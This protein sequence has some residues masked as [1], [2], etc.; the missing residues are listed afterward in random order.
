MFFLIFYTEK[1]SIKFTFPLPLRLECVVYYKE[2][3]RTE[4]GS[5]MKKYLLALDEGTTSARAI[6]FDRAGHIAAMA[7]QP[8][9]QIYPHPGWVEQDPMDIYAA[10][11]AALT[12][13]VAKS[14]IDPCEIAAAGITNQRE[15]ALLWDRTTGSPVAPAIVWQCRRTAD[16]C[17][18]LYDSG[19]DAM[20]RRKTGL[21]PDA[22]FSATKWE[23]MFREDPAL[24]AR[25]RNG[26][27]AAGTVDTWL[28]WKLTD[29]KIHVTDRTNAAR[30]MLYNIR[31]GTW[32]DELLDLFGIPR[33]VLP[34]VRSSG[35]VYGEIS[36][37]GTPV[38]L[39]GIAGDQQSALFG[40]RC[41]APGDTKN[42]Y[43]TGCFLLMHTGETAVDS[44]SGLLTTVAAGEVGRPIEYALEGSV[45][46]GGAVIQWLRDEMRLIDH[47]AQSEEVARSVPDTGGVYVVPAFTGLGAPYWDPHA[48]GTIT[49]LTRGSGRA[50]IV[51]AAL[52]SIAYQTEDVLSAMCTDVGRSIPAL[53]M[54]GGAS[55]NDFLMQFQSDLSGVPVLRPQITEATA[56]GAACLAGLGVGFYSSRDEIPENEIAARF[57]P[58]IDEDM[59]TAL[60]DGWKKAVAAARIQ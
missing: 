7:N 20:I 39:A 9:R 21:R 24:L 15:T 31:T 4:G 42:T 26:E 36:V 38:P 32:D 3:I 14:G 10:E 53:R 55:A 45:F 33:C 29:G 35:E 60:A 44:A 51:R 48:R 12:E 2:E 17:T 59:R 28:A 34:E 40:H 52:E 23:W 57:L 43:G 58:Q 25:A 1:I 18:E 37:L 13:C 8:I 6:L 47:A 41:F 46:V 56:W 54:D 27:L 22:Y 16:R 11:M 50:H 49:G 5:S 30:T 19:C